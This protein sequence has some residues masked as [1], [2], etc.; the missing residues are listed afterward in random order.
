MI[1]RIKD[2]YGFLT[3]PDKPIMWSHAPAGYGK[4]AIAGTISKWLEEVRGGSGSVLYEKDQREHA[5][6]LHRDPTYR[7]PIRRPP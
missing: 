7:Q 2:W 3:K 6:R 5:V 4:T 1:V